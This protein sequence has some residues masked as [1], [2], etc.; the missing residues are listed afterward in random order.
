MANHLDDRHQVLR[1]TLS[2]GG[3]SLAL[4]LEGLDL[5]IVRRQIAAKQVE[6]DT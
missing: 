3:P 4:Y 6:D 2:P 5:Q 1:S